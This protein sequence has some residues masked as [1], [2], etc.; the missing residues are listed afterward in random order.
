M[1]GEH[2]NDFYAA[3][4]ENTGAKLKMAKTK[5][6]SQSDLNDMVPKL[7][8]FVSSLSPSQQ[9][10][11]AHPFAG[12][13]AHPKSQKAIQKFLDKKMGKLNPNTKPILTA[14][15]GGVVGTSGGVVSTSKGTADGVVAT[16][17]GSSGGVVAASKGASGGVVGT[18]SG[19]SG[20]VV[21]T[22]AG[23]AAMPKKNPAKK[24]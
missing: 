21:E 3:G 24:K 14:V 18:S 11:L 17:K 10:A 2:P 16:S 22:A 15:A 5:Q 20:G 4:H 23:T 9:E 8:Q 1:P 19:T 7:N 6:V 13:P 12:A